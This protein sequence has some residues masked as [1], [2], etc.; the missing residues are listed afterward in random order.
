M[1]TV[2]WWNYMYRSAMKE[3]HAQSILS[4][5]GIGLGFTIA[6][7][8]D[9]AKLKSKVLV[10]LSILKCELCK[11]NLVHNTRF[12]NLSVGYTIFEYFQYGSVST[13]I[14]VL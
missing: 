12:S 1:Y 7:M 8:C 9:P 14:V 6:K 13:C 11:N 3:C 10:A 4:K 5:K 2:Y